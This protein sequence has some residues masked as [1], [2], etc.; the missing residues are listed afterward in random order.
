MTWLLHLVL[1]T[2]LASPE[3]SAQ[4]LRAL[5]A[6]RVVV[7]SDTGRGGSSGLSM[8][9][10]EATAE[11]IWQVVLDFDAYVDFL[12]YVT[13]SWTEGTPQSLG[14]GRYRWGMELTTRGVTTRYRVDC[15]REDKGMLDWAMTPVGVSPMRGSTGSWQ[16]LP[17]DQQRVLLVYVATVDTAWWVP[18]SVHRQAADRGLSGIVELVAQQAEE[19]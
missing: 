10:V 1:N 19:R 9:L 2:P 15:H 16:V 7:R 14:S 11:R 18:P 5:E 13:A 4:E 3:P 12:P 17:W 6:G 8:R